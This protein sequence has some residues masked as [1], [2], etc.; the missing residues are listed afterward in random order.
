MKMWH[1]RQIS[2]PMW[3]AN[4][5]KEDIVPIN[6]YIPIPLLDKK[7]RIIEKKWSKEEIIKTFGQ[8][9]EV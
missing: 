5:K 1:T 2:Y 4:A 8:Y 7:E 6:K 9:Y 3:F